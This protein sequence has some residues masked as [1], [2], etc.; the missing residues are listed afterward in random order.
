VDLF[1]LLS[2]PIL[3]LPSTLSLAFPDENPAPNRA[4]GV[5]VPVFAIA[6]LPLAAFPEWVRGTWSG[7]R[8]FGA[9]LAALAGLVA[10]AA[11]TNHHLV[12]SRYAQ[13]MVG[14]S[15]N[16][17]EAG[18]VIRWFATSVGDY[19]HVHVLCHPHWMDSRLVA[20]HAGAPGRDF[21]V[22]CDRKM[23]ELSARQ[24]VEQPQ[25]FLLHPDD[26]EGLAVLQSV[27]PSGE[28][29]RYI[30]AYEGKDFLSFYVHGASGP[31]RLEFEAEQ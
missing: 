5:M 27:F 19:D 12:F 8:A 28:L 9:S 14:T 30:S 7:K 15:W 6:A 26:E 29:S 2:I 11:S 17:A 3:M 13:D 25:L 31:A 16:T 4:S 21:A 23:E 20:I 1:A 22:P 24:D 18:Q 10:L